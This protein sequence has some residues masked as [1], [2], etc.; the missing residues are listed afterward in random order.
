MKLLPSEVNAARRILPVLE[1]YM[2][3][4]Y[5]ATLSDAVEAYL[6]ELGYDNPGPHLTIPKEEM[7][8]LLMRIGKSR[9]LDKI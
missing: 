6:E 9:G 1:D 2:E 7:R 8:D 3:E 4:Y 5:R